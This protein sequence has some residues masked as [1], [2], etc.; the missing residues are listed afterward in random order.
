MTRSDHVERVEQN[1]GR[2][3]VRPE[4]AAKT[5]SAPGRITRPM[6]GERL[7]RGLQ[8]M[9]ISSSAPD[10]RDPNVSKLRAVISEQRFTRYLTEAGGDE[11]L[12][13]ELYEW[14]IDVASA[15]HLPLH[16]IEITLRT[17]SPRASAACTD[18][19]G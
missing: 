7:H 14:G 11:Q 1:R 9:S 15:L 13:W 8:V 16:A 12:A 19:H 18:G 3:V 10:G 6:A 4:R 5:E 17:A 2:P